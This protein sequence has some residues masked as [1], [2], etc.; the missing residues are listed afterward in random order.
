MGSGYFGM[1]FCDYTHEGVFEFSQVGECTKTLAEYE[2]EGRSSA[3]FPRVH[4]NKA[5]RINMLQRTEMPH[6]GRLFGIF[7]LAVKYR[8]ADDNAGGFM[9]SLKLR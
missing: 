1:A 6:L 4:A 9:K 3:S 7:R 8:I 5:T 2:K